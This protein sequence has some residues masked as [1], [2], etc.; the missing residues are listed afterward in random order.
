[1]APIHIRA[2][3]STSTWIELTAGTGMTSAAPSGTSAATKP[4][5]PATA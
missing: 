3:T 4:A 1:M 5:R 2:S